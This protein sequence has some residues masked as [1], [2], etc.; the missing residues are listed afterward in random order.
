MNYND[1]HSFIFCF[2]KKA[3]T[4][5]INIVNLHKSEHLVAVLY[6][7]DNFILFYKKVWQ[8]ILILAEIML[9][10]ALVEIRPLVCQKTWNSTH[11]S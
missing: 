9:C 11:A 1:T 6:F 3:G 8:S 4:N 5:R 7:L 10:S 2:I